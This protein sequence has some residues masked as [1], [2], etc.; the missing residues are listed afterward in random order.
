MTD[1]TPKAIEDCHELLRWLIP[2]LDKFPR[3]HRFT[4]GERLETALLQ[5]LDKQ[6]PLSIYRLHAQSKAL[7]M[8]RLKTL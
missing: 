4:L 2:Q 3:N 6:R 8:V 7:I 5:V 1:Q